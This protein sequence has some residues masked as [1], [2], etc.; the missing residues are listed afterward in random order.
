[1]TSEWDGTAWAGSVVTLPLRAAPITGPAE[2]VGKAETGG[3]VGNL[4]SNPYLAARQQSPQKLMR[5]AQ[6][7]FEKLRTPE[8]AG[9]E[10]PEMDPS[11]PDAGLQSAQISPLD[12]ID[13][14]PQSRT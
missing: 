8:P 3:F 1:M 6:V 13:R 4:V 11:K 10:D 12:R 2:V 7:A 5:A 9:P 14:S